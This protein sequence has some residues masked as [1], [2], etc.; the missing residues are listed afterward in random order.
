MTKRQQLTRTLVEFYQKPIAQVSLELFLS[1]AAVIFFA[2]FA[3]RPT[4]LTMSDLIKEIDDKKVLDKQLTQ[5]IA[6]LSSAQTEYNNYQARLPVLDEAIPGQPFLINTLLIIEKIASDTKMVI[7]A[8]SVSEIP[9][10]EVAD[11]QKTLVRKSYYITL[12]IAGDYQ[13]IRNFVDQILKN[14]RTMVIDTITFATNESRGT[15]QLKANI[16]LN[17]PYF[18]N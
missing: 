2:T 9:K 18:S 1:I 15:K 5:K 10:E 11:Q 17:V 3:I 16:T 8:I 7:T 12:S 13:S 4:L 14:R 6:A